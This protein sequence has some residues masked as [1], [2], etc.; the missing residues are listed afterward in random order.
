MTGKASN[1]SLVKKKRDPDLVNAEIAMKR[2]AQ[3]AREIA[4]KEGTRIVFIE[5]GRIKEE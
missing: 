1:Q 4:K 5:N 2:A 3:K